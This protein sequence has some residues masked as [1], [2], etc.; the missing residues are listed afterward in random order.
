MFNILIYLLL[1]DSILPT[2]SYY[3]G[4]YNLIDINN[5]V[6]TYGVIFNIYFSIY[7]NFYI[8]I[9][10]RRIDDNIIEYLYILEDNFKDKEYY[11]LGRNIKNL[12]EYK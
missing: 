10:Y 3:G 6:F 11:E 9:K 12:I 5:I 1:F 8:N 2:I 4:Y 7:L